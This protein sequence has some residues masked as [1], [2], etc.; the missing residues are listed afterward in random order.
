MR[1]KTSFS[2]LFLIF[3]ENT[4]KADYILHFPVFFDFAELFSIFYGSDFTSFYI[5]DINREK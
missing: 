2:V 4:K 3:G 1:L 5:C